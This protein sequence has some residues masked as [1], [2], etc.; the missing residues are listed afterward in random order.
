MPEKESTENT[1][2]YAGMLQEARAPQEI[3][4]NPGEDY[5]PDKRF[6]QGIPSLEMTTGGRLWAI[7]FAGGQGESSVNY[8]A[9]V[10]SGDGGETWSDLQMVIDPPG[11]VRTYDPAIW[12]DPEGTLWV[13][14]TQAHTLHDGQ[15]GV[16][17]ITTENPDD[18][19]PD[20]SE[21]RRLS[22]G[23]MLNKPVVL[24]NGEWL[25]PISLLPSANIANEKR[26]LPFFLR[27]H[28]HKYMTDEDRKRVDERAAAYVYSST[29]KGKTLSAK[30]AMRVSEECRSHSEHMV[31]EL[32]DGRLWMLVRTNYGIGQSFSPDKGI[33]WTNLEPSGIPHTSS[34]FFI[35]RLR[36]G[37]ILLVKNC[38]MD[39]HDE[40]G[41][42]VNFTRTKMTAFLSEDEG[43]SWKGGLLLEER[44]CTYPDG[45]QSPDGT[46]YV[47][48]DHGRRKDNEILMSRFTEEDILARKVVSEKGK[49]GLL[50]NK[51][52]GV[53][54]DD[55]DWS[56]EKGFDDPNEPLIFT[57]I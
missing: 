35:R 36:S 43:N 33:T 1:P 55:I 14:W 25:F 45:G 37:N 27:T 18:E 52:T 5:S 40:N 42:P 51:A 38:G 56:H 34:R 54:T 6:F 48:Y 28:F 7:W 50:V 49:L 16:W 57:G 31:V 46:I 29:D 32:K 21:P 8:V 9:L 2:T 4:F 53:I 39:E 15:W 3:N 41:D 19:K 44:V 12:Q 26:M 10:T 30:G 11:Q 24:E 20:W 47:I 22:D 13:F 23:I 17:A